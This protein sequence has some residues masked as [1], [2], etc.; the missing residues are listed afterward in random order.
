MSSDIKQKKKKTN[1][2]PPSLLSLPE[3]IIVNCLARIS[4]SYYPKLSL[5][6]KSFCSLLLSMELYV[7]RLELGTHENVLHV[8]FQLPDKTR[9]SWFSLWLKPDQTLT[10]NIGKKKKQ[11]SSGNTLL[12]PIP[13]S[14]SPRVPMFTCAVGSDLYAI[15]K[16]NITPSSV[17]WVRNTS[18]YA[19]RQA[20]SMTVARANAIACVFD[21]KI[22][23][24]GGCVADE[25]TCWAEVF[26]PKTQTWERLPDPG[27]ELRVYSIKKVEVKLGKI[28]VRCTDE[29]E[30]VYDPKEGK[31]DIPTKEFVIESEC[32][33]DNVRYRCGRESCL[34]YDVK[35]DEWKAVKG[36]ATLNG[37]RR[38]CFVEI[39]NYGGKLLI[40][41]GKF[42]PPRRQNKN[43]WCAVIAL[44]RRN[45][46]DE[47]WGKVEWA[48]VVLTV[49]RSYVFLRCEVKPV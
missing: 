16:Y 42:A 33:I 12:V 47:V 1:S 8:C 18:T 23:V 17:M 21:D 40:L 3:E 41:W 20:P 49:P 38:C 37:N 26:D 32:D 13:S 27:A 31:W 4:K 10:N 43:I 25:S 46:G 15:S 7:A 30:C 22:Y 14:Y 34:W 48:S 28:Y 5:V 29:M 44:E 36:L 24:M 6:C 11:N 2:S 39:A 19:W 45:N 9:P 35:H